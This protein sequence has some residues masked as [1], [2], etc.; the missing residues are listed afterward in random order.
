MYAVK[1]KG[2]FVTSS[3]ATIKLETTA[4]QD[5]IGAINAVGF[6]LR[7]LVSDD[8]AAAVEKVASKAFYDRKYDTYIPVSSLG[9][10]WDILV[11][12]SNKAI[13]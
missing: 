10:C 6:S 2:K 7:G 12:V 13:N 8:I 3:L 1:V 5:Y 4:Y 9:Y 11:S